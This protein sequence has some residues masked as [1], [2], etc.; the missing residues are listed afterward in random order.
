MPS[1]FHRGIIPESGWCL[2]SQANKAIR[3]V[4]SC[5]EWYYIRIVHLKRPVTRL[6]FF[7]LT[8]T[9]VQYTTFRTD[10]ILGQTYFG[11]KPSNQTES[12][13][14]SGYMGSLML[15][16]SSPSTPTTT[17]ASTSLP[18]V[19]R[20][21]FT[22]SSLADVFLGAI[23]NTSWTGVV[24]IQIYTWHQRFPK[25][26][27]H[28]KVM[29]AMLCL[30]GLKLISNAVSSCSNLV[31]VYHL[32]VTSLKD[33]AKESLW[34]YTFII[35]VSA[36]WILTTTLRGLKWM[37]PQRME[38]IFASCCPCLRNWMKSIA[39]W[40]TVYGLAT[41]AVNSIFALVGL[42]SNQVGWLSGDILA[43]AANSVSTPYSSRL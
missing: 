41:G 40:V 33:L 1:L 29:I 34:Y 5:K 24:H 7:S 20:S 25:D 9:I 39:H 13:T 30:D 8:T 27:L 2:P 21:P 37:A 42:I 26:P 12:V 35:L 43:G 18:V 17:I 31:V 3:T 32:L 28:I 10:Y 19:A 38:G 16:L 11:R 36:L 14:I 4:E 22:L 23:I 15:R 6:Q